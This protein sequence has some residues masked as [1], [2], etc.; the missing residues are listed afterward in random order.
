M[1]HIILDSSHALLSLNRVD[2]WMISEEVQLMRVYCDFQLERKSSHEESHS[3]D[4]DCRS[5]LC[6]VKENYHQFR[7]LSKLVMH[8]LRPPI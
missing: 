3:I 8:L 1:R 4:L 5:K 6:F 2:C 7:V